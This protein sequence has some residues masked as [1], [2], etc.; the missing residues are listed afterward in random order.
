V[1]R[2]DDVGS[3]HRVIKNWLKPEELRTLLEPDAAVIEVEQFERD[4]FVCYRLRS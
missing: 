2:R 1:G 3:R 4:W